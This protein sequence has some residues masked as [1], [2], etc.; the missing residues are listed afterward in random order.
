MQCKTQTHQISSLSLINKKNNSPF[1]QCPCGLWV[2]S[3]SWSS[4][5]SAVWDS[6]STR[7]AS[8]KA[9]SPRRPERGK[10]AEDAGRRTRREK[11]ERRK[12]WETLCYVEFIKK[13]FREARTTYSCFISNNI[14]RNFNVT[15]DMAL[16]EFCVVFLKTLMTK[17]LYLHVDLLFRKLMLQCFLLPLTNILNRFN[18]K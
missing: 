13:K 6:A 12:R 16:S 14:L 2:P 1:F 3:W 10:E 18:S 11:K 7:S 5:L 9:K 17:I 8:T 15:L 4:H